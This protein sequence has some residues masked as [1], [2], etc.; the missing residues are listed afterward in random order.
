MRVSGNSIEFLPISLLAAAL[1]TSSGAQ[2]NAPVSVP[3][4]RII[5]TNDF[6]AVGYDEPSQRFLVRNS[7]GDGWGMKGYFTIPYAYLTDSS[8]ADD[9]W[10]MRTISH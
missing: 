6:E 5:G 4:L 8:L 1:W 7:W 2:S 9:F 3:R 10:T